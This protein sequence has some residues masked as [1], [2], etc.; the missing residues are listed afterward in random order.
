MKA[1]VKRTEFGGTLVIGATVMPGAM[2][3]VAS[4]AAL[5]DVAKSF[6]FGGLPEI[7][8]DALSPFTVRLR[9]RCGFGLDLSLVLQSLGAG[10]ISHAMA[11]LFPA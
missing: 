8:R 9:S 10:F 2:E 6:Q 5:S 1:M 4:I 11:D 3:F 7:T